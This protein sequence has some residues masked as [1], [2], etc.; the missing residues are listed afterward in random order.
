MDLKKVGRNHQKSYL[1]KTLERIWIKIYNIHK[2]VLT[3][4]LIKRLKYKVDNRRLYIVMLNK[5]I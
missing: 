2:N 1:L 4:I 3:F 5:N